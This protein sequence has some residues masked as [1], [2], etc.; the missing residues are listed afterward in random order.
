[1]YSKKLV[2]DKR[3]RVDIAAVSESLARNEVSV[4]VSRYS[5]PGR[6]CDKHEASGYKLLNILKEGRMQD[7]LNFKH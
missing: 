3:L 2:D 1:M 7:L 5:P 6:L 4:M